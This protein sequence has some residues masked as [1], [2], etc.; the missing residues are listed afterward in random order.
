MV[1]SYLQSM[2]LNNFVFINRYVLPIRIS[3]FANSARPA[4]HRGFNNYIM[5]IECNILS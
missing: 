1:I 5:C 3:F 2:L 4:C